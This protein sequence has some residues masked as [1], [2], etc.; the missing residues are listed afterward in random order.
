MFSSAARAGGN[1]PFG[2]SRSGGHASTCSDKLRVFMTRHDVEPT[3]NACERTLRPSVI[4][5]RVTNAF[6]SDWRAKAYADF[7]SIA[8]TARL[9][10]RNILAAI[11]AALTDPP[12]A[13]HLL[14]TG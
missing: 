6:R 4:F 11:R 12:R 2:S 7:C 5:R 13:I 3:N 14:I 10:G 1:I 9:N 8:A